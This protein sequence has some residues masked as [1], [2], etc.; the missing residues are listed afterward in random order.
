MIYI[1]SS[2]DTTSDAQYT[3]VST[4]SSTDY[5]GTTSIVSNSYSD[6]LY[7]V[8]QTS[9]KKE[10]IDIVRLYDR[11]FEEER[12]RVRFHNQIKYK[13]VMKKSINR[14]FIKIRNVI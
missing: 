12:N 3:S 2:A 11:D 10:E 8:T 6:Y 13:G 5:T 1:S 9:Y 7:E 4:Q 14:H